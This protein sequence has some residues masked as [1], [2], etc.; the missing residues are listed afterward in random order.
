MPGCH[1]LVE[2]LD[3]IG[4]REL[5]ELLVHVVCSRTRVVTKPYTE[6]LDFQ[7]LLFMNLRG[8]HRARDEKT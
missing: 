5:A 6:V 4:T 7:W 8:P 3:G 1:I 2:A